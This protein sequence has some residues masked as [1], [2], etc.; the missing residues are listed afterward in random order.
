MKRAQLV[1]AAIA[2]FAVCVLVPIAGAAAGPADA[3]CQRHVHR[4][5]ARDLVRFHGNGS[6]S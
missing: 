1:V 2:A 3:T 5:T 6:A 4:G